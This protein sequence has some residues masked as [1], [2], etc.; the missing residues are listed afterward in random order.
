MQFLT[1]YCIFP[2]WREHGVLDLI[3][4]S[5]ISFSWILLGQCNDDYWVEMF[6]M[7]K[8]IVFAVANLFPPHMQKYDL[9]YQ[10]AI[11]VLLCIACTLFKLIHSVSL[12]ICNQMFVGKR[13]QCL[14]LWRRLFVPSMTHCDMKL[15]G[16]EDN[17]CWTVKQTFFL[18]CWLAKM[19]GAINGT[20][21]SI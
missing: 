16:W 4:K 5:S 14:W 2:F 19:V 7:T 6:C 12:I 15:C 10:L 3:P 20:Y 17:G 18:L 13:V 1:L 11:H 9:K 8:D 21:I